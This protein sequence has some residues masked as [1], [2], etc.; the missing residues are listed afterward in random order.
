MF[1]SPENQRCQQQWKGIGIGLRSCHYPYIEKNKPKVDWFEVLADNYLGQGDSSLYHLDSICAS[2]PVTLHCVGMSLGSTD[3]VNL[4]YLRKLKKLIYRVQPLKISDHL[5]WSSFNGQFFHELLPLPYTEESVLHVSQRIKI[6]Q[7]F[8][9]QQI[10]IENVS[11]YLSFKHSSLT[12]W[13]F[14]KAVADEANCQILLDINNI[15]VSAKNNHFNPFDYLHELFSNHRIAQ[16]HLGG[17]QDQGTHLLDTHGA[18]IQNP[19]WE[20]FAE[21]VHQF[22]FIPTAIEWDNH[23]PHFSDLMNE[24]LRAKKIIENREK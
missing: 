23:I 3:P 22:G 2:Y 11:S 6:I 15:Y 5:C 10:M 16:F 14:L 20:L 9:E 13:E 12:E 21:A 4:T 8:L 17:Y 19:V 24:A 7:D 18:Y 1:K